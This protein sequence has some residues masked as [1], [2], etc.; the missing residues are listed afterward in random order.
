MKNF[1]ILTSCII[2][3]SLCVSSLAM[4]DST[5]D[6]SQNWNL[7]RGTY[8]GASAGTV[9]TYA[10]IGSS[11]GKG[12]DSGHRGFAGGADVG[13]N[14]TP[15]FALEG[16][17]LVAATRNNG[18]DD[19]K[20][21]NSILH[22]TVPYVTTKFTIPLATRWAINLKAGLMYLHN[23]DNNKNTDPDSKGPSFLILPFTGAGV[24]YSITPH[25]D[26]DAHYQ[27]AVYGI[28]G[29][30]QAGA[31]LTYHFS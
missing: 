21:D 31:G 22:Y 2:A 16:G 27:G 30:G 19:S 1:K 13:Y 5:T 3:G 24:S 20:S 23:P 29:M 25:L 10:A 12:L 14:F 28:V 9:F 26:I 18:I 17:A 15:K 4:A 7:H 8:V 6:L 11:N